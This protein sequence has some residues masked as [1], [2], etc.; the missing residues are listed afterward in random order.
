M[1]NGHSRFSAWGAG[2]VLDVTVANLSHNQYLYA[3]RAFGVLD[4][5]NGASDDVGPIVSGPLLKPEKQVS[6]GSEFSRFG[7]VNILVAPALD[8]E[9]LTSVRASVASL[10]QGVLDFWMDGPRDGAL[11]IHGRVLL[12]VLRP[13]I[14]GA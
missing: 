10:T 14:H 2:N 8:V 11:S 4:L 9:D 12:D 13:F 3:G 1:R 5:S 6:L 7:Y